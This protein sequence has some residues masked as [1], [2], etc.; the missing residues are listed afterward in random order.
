MKS[1]VPK[2]AVP[3]LRTLVAATLVALVVASAILVAFVLPAEYGIDPLRTGRALG[4]TDLAN[5]TA[6]GPASQPAGAVIA[7]PTIKGVFI[8]ERGRWQLD[9]RE[10]TL[11]A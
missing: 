9:S 8:P 10:F 1:E 4:L 11:S 3:P 6:T 2:S 7:A 5:A